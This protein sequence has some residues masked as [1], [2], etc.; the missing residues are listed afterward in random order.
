M[1]AVTRAIDMPTLHGDL[2]VLR[3]LRVE[4][5]ERVAAIQTE[6]AVARWWG[7]PDLDDLLRKAEGRDDVMVDHRVGD[8]VGEECPVRELLLRRKTIDLPLLL[9][10]LRDAAER[11]L[12]LLGRRLLFIEDGAREGRIPLR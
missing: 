5:V 3:P 4:D 6:P 11:L 12:G 9:P 10:H 2:V 7:P 1:R 8:A